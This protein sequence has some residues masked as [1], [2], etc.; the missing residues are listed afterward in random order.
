[1]FLTNQFMCSFVWVYRCGDP[2]N[3]SYMGRK[4]TVVNSPETIKFVLS[5]AHASFPP[6]YSK[7]FTRLLGEGRFAIPSKYPYYRKAVLGAVTGDGLLNLLPFISSLAEKTVQSWE[8]Q[9]FVNTVEET[10][11]V[12]HHLSRSHSWLHD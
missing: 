2:Y 12:V 7:Q 1:M 10:Q 8:T 5:T 11:K 6:A 3:I 4:I 9:Q